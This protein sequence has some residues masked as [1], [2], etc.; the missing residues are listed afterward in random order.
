M[1]NRKYACSILSIQKAFF[2]LSFLPS[3]LTVWVAKQGFRF[4]W[5]KEDNSDKDHEKK[6]ILSQGQAQGGQ[7]C[8]EFGAQSDLREG[9]WPTGV[10][11]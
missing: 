5:F 10:F 9:S 3:K 1:F 7:S 2:K 11:L 8:M 6:S 4:P